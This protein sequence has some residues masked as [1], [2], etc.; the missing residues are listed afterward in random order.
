MI[1]LPGML[2]Q[3]G[4]DWLEIEPVDSFTPDNLAPG[5]VVDD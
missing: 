4:I 5:E 3:T 1:Y 2:S